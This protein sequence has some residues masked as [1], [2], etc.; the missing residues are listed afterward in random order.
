MHV[1][2]S[3]STEIFWTSWMYTISNC[4]IITLLF[5][6]SRILHFEQNSLLTLNCALCTITQFR[7]AQMNFK[8]TF[9]LSISSIFSYKYVSVQLLIYKLIFSFLRTK[10]LYQ[11]HV[12]KY[13]PCSIFGKQVFI[14]DNELY[15]SFFSIVWL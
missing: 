13:M 4:I 15:I 7:I 8:Q 5:L 12:P 10:N 9:F 11:W 2:I 1:K 6:I 3:M 14:I